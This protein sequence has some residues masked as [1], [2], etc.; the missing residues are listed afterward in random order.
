MKSSLLILLHFRDILEV[1]QFGFRLKL[2]P[3]ADNILSNLSITCPSLCLV[4]CLTADQQQAAGL[5]AAADPDAAAS[6]ATHP[7]SAETRPGSPAAHRRHAVS[8]ARCVCTHTHTRIRRA[9]T[10]RRF[11]K[12]GVSRP[13]RTRA[14]IGLR[15]ALPVKPR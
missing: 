4:F 13:N 14:H 9:L 5:P 2:H 11:V 7:Q 10:M 6:T 8:S 15:S 3:T 1:S 12:A